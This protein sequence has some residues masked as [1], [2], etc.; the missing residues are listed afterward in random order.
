MLA[1]K[2]NSHP[3]KENVLPSEQKGCRKESRETKGQLHID[4]TVLRDCKR[5]HTNLAMTWID[6]KKAYD[7]VTPEL[8]SQ[9]LRNVWY[10]KKCTRFLK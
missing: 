6:F 8:D 10:C 2:M 9:V 7:M 5:R 3:E 4:K 1:E